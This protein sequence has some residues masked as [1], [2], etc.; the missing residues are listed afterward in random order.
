MRVWEITGDGIDALRL[1]DR[2][3]I[4]LGPR[5]VRV[6]VDAVALNY[7]DLSTVKAACS[8]ALEAQDHFGAFVVER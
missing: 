8:R 6:R 5:Q 2:T 3:A 7:R 4:A 1:T